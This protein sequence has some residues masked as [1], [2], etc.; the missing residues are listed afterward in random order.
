[1]KIYDCTLWFL[2]CIRTRT[3]QILDDNA[4]FMFI[5]FIFIT[6]LFF[7]GHNS[8]LS[9]HRILSGMSCCT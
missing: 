8:S 4:N 1:M 5:L 9:F 2:F 7:S 6:L 3:F